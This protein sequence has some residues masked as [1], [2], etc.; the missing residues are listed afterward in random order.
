[1]VAETLPTEVEV[2]IAFGTGKLFQY[3]GA[4][5]IAANH[6][7]EKSLALSMFHA[8]TGTDVDKMQHTICK[9]KKA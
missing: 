6:G 3:L 5:Q 2:W 9:W 4:H 1:M 7:L 8:L